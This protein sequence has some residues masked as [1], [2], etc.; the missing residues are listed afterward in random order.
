MFICFFLHIFYFCQQLPIII[1]LCLRLHLP[2]YISTLNCFDLEWGFF[3]TTVVNFCLKQHLYSGYSSSSSS[4]SLQ[5]ARFLTFFYRFLI[6]FLE[7]ESEKCGFTVQAT[8]FERK[9]R[10]VF[11]CVKRVRIRSCSGPQFCRIFPHSD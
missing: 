7:D 8:A 1:R 9:W 10:S 2:R 4:F 5:I 6:L 11:H 3:L